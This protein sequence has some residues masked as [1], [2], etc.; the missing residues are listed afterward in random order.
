MPVDEHSRTLVPS[1]WAL[2]DGTN[3]ANLMPIAIR[4]SHV[5]ADTVLGDRPTCVDHGLIPTAVFSTPEIGTLGMSEARA[6]EEHGE[7]VVIY[8]TSF[9]PM[10]ATISERD[11]RMLLKFVVHGPSSS[12]SR[13]GWVSYGVRVSWA[14]ETRTKPPGCRP[15]PLGGGFPRAARAE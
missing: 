11:E 12:S 7:S 6:S 14:T 15:G 4:K 10:K 2:G 5:F 13:S 9:K 3:R 1:I 8:K